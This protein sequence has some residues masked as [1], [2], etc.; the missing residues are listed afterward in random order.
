MENLINK[1]QI[2]IQKSG[3]DVVTPI[4]LSNLVFNHYEDI[5]GIEDSNKYNEGHWPQEVY[6]LCEYYDITIDEFQQAWEFN[7]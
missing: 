6:D 1:F 2:L 7:F 4:V 5:T 3:E